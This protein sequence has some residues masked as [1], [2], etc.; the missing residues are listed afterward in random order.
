MNSY[1]IKLIDF[2]DDIGF[3][4]RKRTRNEKEDIN[5]LDLYKEKK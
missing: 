4:R 5:L 3:L 1:K 2:A